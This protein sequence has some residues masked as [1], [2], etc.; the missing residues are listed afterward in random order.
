MLVVDIYVVVVVCYFVDVGHVVFIHTVY[1]VVDKV[2]V[3]GGLNGSWTPEPCNFFENEIWQTLKDTKYPRCNIDFQRYIVY[4]QNFRYSHTSTVLGKNLLLTGGFFSPN[5]TE[6]L[7][8]GG[9]A[10]VESFELSPPLWDHCAIQVGGLC[11]LGE[12]AK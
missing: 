10:S 2:V 5:T 6:L 3:C 1:Q 7:S 12:A 9:D 11:F 4:T 8:L